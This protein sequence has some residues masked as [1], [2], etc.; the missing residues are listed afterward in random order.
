MIGLL[1]SILGPL[2]KVKPTPPHVPLGRDPVVFRASERYLAY[3]YLSLV[4][5]LFPTFLVPVVMPIGILIL[6]ARGKPAPSFVWGIWIVLSL[7]ALVGAA[8]ALVSV[9]LDYEFHCYV[10]TD[11]SLRIRRGI[12]EQVEA[13]LTF[14]NVQNVR[15]VQGPLQRLFGIASVVVDT[16]GSAGK[17]SEGQDPFL[18]HHR[19]VIR[20]IADAQT[21]RDR[22]MDR[23]RQSKSAGLGDLDDHSDRAPEVGGGTQLEL[24][25]TIRDE[26]RGLAQDLRAAPGG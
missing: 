25:H 3:R 24:L 8:L 15:V 10:M 13:T 12:W 1:V 9:R 26:A 21:L 19:G 7:A 22:I 4:W 18:L 14:A 11:R 6:A 17:V 2:L 23:M 20:G 16:A 5:M